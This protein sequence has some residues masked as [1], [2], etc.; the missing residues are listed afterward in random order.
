MHLWRVRLSWSNLVSW[1][2]ADR[3]CRSWTTH[4]WP[5]QPGQTAPLR[6][7][8]KKHTH[9]LYVTFGGSCCFFAVSAAVSNKGKS[10]K[11]TWFGSLSWDVIRA[12]DSCRHSLC[13]SQSNRNKAQRDLAVTSSPLTTACFFFFVCFFFP[14]NKFYL[15]SHLQRS[16]LLWSRPSFGSRTVRPPAARP[17]SPPSLRLPYPGSRSNLPWPRRLHPSPSTQSGEQ[18]APGP[19]PSAWWYAP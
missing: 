4:S 16:E 5:P 6:L 8:N 1:W 15:L 13:W 10:N 19:S 2:R 7:R 18:R 17:L 14:Q 3:S 11:C 12:I 9:T